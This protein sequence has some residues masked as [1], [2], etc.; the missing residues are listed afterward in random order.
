MW[1]MKEKVDQL[2]GWICGYLTGG[3][4]RG[5]SRGRVDSHAEFGMLIRH[6]TGAVKQTVMDRKGM[7][8]REICA[9]YDFGETSACSEC[10]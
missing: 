8:R 6:S 7:I 4:F 10:I 9:G 5:R 3:G 2:E 1:G